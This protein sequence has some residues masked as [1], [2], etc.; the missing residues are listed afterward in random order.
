MSIPL[1]LAVLGLVR[2]AIP[3]PA[4]CT[5]KEISAGKTLAWC[6]CLNGFLCA[7]LKVPLDYQRPS[8]SWASVP[9]VKIP[10]HSNSPDGP[11]QGM[12]LINPGGPGGSGIIEALNNGTTIQTFVGTNWDI[13]GFDPRGIGFSE[14]AANCSTKGAFPRNTISRSVPRVTDEFYNSYIEYG[15]ELGVR[16]EE[17]IGGERNAGQHMSTATTARDMLSIVEAFARTDDG[18]RAA[19]PCEL[20]NYYGISY[21]TFLGQTFASMVPQRVG[22]VILDGVVSTESYLTIWTSVALNRLDGVIAA[23]FIYCHE[24]GPSDCPYYTGNTAKAIFERFNRSFLQLDPRQAEAENW[25]N[26]TDLEAAL[27][28]LKVSL[29]SAADMPFAYFG[30]IPE[31]LVSLEAAL[32]AQD[33]R[34]WTEQL[35]TINGVGNPS[36]VGWEN[37][38][39]TLGVVCSDNNKRWYNK[40]LE[41]FRPQLEELERQ[42][43]VGEVWSKTILGCSGWPIK[44]NDI[45][46]GP[47]GGDTAT[48]ILFVSNTYDPVTPIEKLVTALLTYNSSRSSLQKQLDLVRA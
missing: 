16:C 35:A 24:S 25:S 15:K 44:S 20:L 40:T 9:L 19:K 18:K 6:P 45:F 13:V 7:K 31:I 4:H 37:P 43:I 17:T 8:L 1:A 11:Y 29:L 33:I 3:T 39:R 27:L 28:T 14:P 36:P 26:A 23:F 32:A 22:N 30:L 42:S 2:L 38:E 12:S 47:F 21:G 10:A 34:P 41:D 48:S 46:S 5:F